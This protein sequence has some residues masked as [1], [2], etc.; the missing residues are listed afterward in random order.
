[1]YSVAVVN[2]ILLLA[3][4]LWGL[5]A[6]PA[7]TPPPTLTLRDGRTFQLA[8]PARQENGRVIFTTTEGKTYSLDAADVRSAVDRPPASTRTPKVY[9]PMDSQNLGA[10][11]REER[12]K[13]GK[14]TELSSPRATA[15]PGKPRPTRS[16]TP[17]AK[18]TPRPTRTPTPVPH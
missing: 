16:P 4:P 8:A 10:I 2:T 1:M 3:L 14:T 17:G 15:S 5:L 9:N 6:G 12:A 13:T 7:A 18:K 11:A